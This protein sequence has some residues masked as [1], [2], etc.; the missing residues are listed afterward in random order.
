M[1]EPADNPFY[2]RWGDRLTFRLFFVTQNL[3]LHFPRDA[4]MQQ[5]LTFVVQSIDKKHYRVHH[6][7]F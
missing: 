6:S 5:I 7:H 4:H 1:C 2:D 3:F